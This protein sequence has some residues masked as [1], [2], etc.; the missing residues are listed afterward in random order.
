MEL[1]Y[2]L[3]TLAPSC[4]TVLSVGSFDGVHLGHQALLRTLCDTAKR[5][6][7]EAVVVT[8]EPHPRIALGR[9][10]GFQ[11]LTDTAEKAALMAEYGVNRVVVLP[12]DKDFAALSGEAFARDILQQHLQATVLVAGYNHRFGHDRLSAQALSIEGLSV[13]EVGACELEGQRISSTLIRNLIAQ[14]D[15]T[16]AERFLGHTIQLLQR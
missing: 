8:F 14:G 6:D 7:A 3:P 4:K 13:I 5:A 10:E 2:G 15:T 12:F 9:G 16:A 11:L 1:H